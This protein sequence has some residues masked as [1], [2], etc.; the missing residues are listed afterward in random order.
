MGFSCAGYVLWYS[1]VTILA[2]VRWCGVGGFMGF[3][4]VVLGLLWHRFYVFICVGWLAAW[5]FGGFFC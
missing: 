2:C 4:V 3:R 1:A 5:W